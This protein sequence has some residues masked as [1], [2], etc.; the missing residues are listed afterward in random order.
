MELAIFLPGQGTQQKAGWE[1][2]L[3][4]S[5]HAHRG[6]DLERLLYSMFP[7]QHVELEEEG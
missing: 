6:Q 4:Q 3:G 1:M 2:A 5:W 7:A